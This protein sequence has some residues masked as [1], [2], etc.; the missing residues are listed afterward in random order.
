LCEK[1]VKKITQIEEE[2]RLVKV[3]FVQQAGKDNVRALEQL[4]YKNAAKEVQ[5]RIKENG[6]EKVTLPVEKNRR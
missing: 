4:G 2:C 3:T 6:G 5:T 1:K